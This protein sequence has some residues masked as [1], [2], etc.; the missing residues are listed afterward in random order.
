VR[1]AKVAQLA[2]QLALQL[3]WSPSG[4]RV[5]PPEIVWEA[6]QT[7]DVAGLADDWL[8]HRQRA[9]AAPRKMRM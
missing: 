2:A 5:V 6:G 3:P 7:G 4:T 8:H 1:A 9:S